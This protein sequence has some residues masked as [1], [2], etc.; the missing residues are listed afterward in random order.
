MLDGSYAWISAGKD[1][2]LFRFLVVLFVSS[3][4]AAHSTSHGF[5]HEPMPLQGLVGYGISMYEPSCAFGCQKILQKSQLGCSTAIGSV[6]G[7]ETADQC[8]A[9]NKPYLL[10][11]ASCLHE[12]CEE[13]SWM[14]SR[15]WATQ[16]AH[17]PAYGFREALDLSG[18]S[19]LDVL[20]PGAPLNNPHAI[21]RDDWKTADTSMHDFAHTEAKSSEFALLLFFTILV[22]PLLLSSAAWL[23]FGLS[24]RFERWFLVHLIYPPLFRQPSPLLKRF[25][26]ENDTPTRGQALLIVAYT[27]QNLLFCFLGHYVRWP[28]IYFDTAHGAF[29]DTLANRTGHL[30]FANL[31][32]LIVYGTR[33]NPLIRI[34]GWSHTTYILFHRWISYIC[35]IHALTH[36]LVYIALHLQVLSHKFAEPYWNA[37]F[38]AFLAFAIIGVTSFSAI[39][40]SHYEVFIDIHVLMAAAALIA[41]YYHIDLKFSHRWGYENWIYV[42][43][44]V[45][46]TERIA[47]ALK[48]ARNGRCTALCTEIDGDYLQ[49]SVQGRPMAGMLYLYLT[50]KARW[51]VWENHPF[52]I[53]SSVAPPDYNDQGTMDQSPGPEDPV[54]DLAE[55]DSESNCESITEIDYA[56][57]S[58]LQGGTRTNPSIALGELTPALPSATGST[59]PLLAGDFEGRCAAWR[60]TLQLII[61]RQSGLTGRSLASSN[62]LS[63]NTLPVLVEGPYHSQINVLEIAATSPHVVCIAGGVGIT[64]ILPLL[65]ARSAASLGRTSLYFG[66][67]T[68]ALARSCGLYDLHQDAPNLEVHV[69]IGARWQMDHIVRQE[70]GEVDEGLVVVCGPRAMVNSVRLAVLDENKCRTHGIIRLI[71]EHFS[72]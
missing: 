45:W 10:S 20:V 27:F 53:A 46:V 38:L 42:S 71:D 57:D 25:L 63:R 13:P 11:L 17:R 62:E 5:T 61:R 60:G 67:R 24:T 9:S 16:N 23:L 39:R 19:P 22:V 26:H 72:W 8:Y 59:L 2:M 6:P 70:L 15:F 30:A 48:I 50:T 65:R 47:R 43:V 1:V 14:V 69:R 33:N 44:V 18:D 12:H 40:R 7:F 28:N 54:F 55:T 21:T 35:I 68:E 36:T 41:C 58:Y 37:G 52:S 3:T 64:A 34:T 56:E 4:A 49:L 29:L 51:R 32:G 66:T 31:A